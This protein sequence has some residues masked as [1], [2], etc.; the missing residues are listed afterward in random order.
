MQQKLQFYGWEREPG[1]F[2]EAA[3]FGHPDRLL[4]MTVTPLAQGAE[5]DVIEGA[6]VVHRGHAETVEAAKREAEALARRR[7]FQAV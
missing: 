7:F 3:A 1:V 4:D 5:F 6:S 2:G